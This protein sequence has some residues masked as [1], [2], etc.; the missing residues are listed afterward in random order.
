MLSVSTLILVC[1]AEH[2]SSLH[3]EVG[4]NKEWLTLTGMN[5]Y[6]TLIYEWLCG[7]ENYSFSKSQEKVTFCL[8]CKDACYTGTNVLMIQL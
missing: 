6:A 1:V 7:N 4:A 3:L 2:N 5:S 8:M